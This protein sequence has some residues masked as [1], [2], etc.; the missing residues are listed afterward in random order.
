MFERFGSFS[1]YVH[2]DK[3]GTGSS[4][5]SVRV[6]NVDD[7]VDDLKA[8]MD[9]AEIDRAHLF[10]QSEAGV[11]TLLF[12]A[13]YPHRVASLIMVDSC[14]R[15][16][17]GDLTAEERAEQIERRTQF[18]KVW[19][20]PDSLAVPLFAPSQVDNHEFRAWFQRYER[21]SASSDSLRDLLIQMIDMDATDV[22]A[23]IEV[24]MLVMHRK[25]D[26]SIPIEFGRQLAD[27][28]RD[29]TFIELEGNDHFAFLGDVEAW[30]NPLERWVTGSVQDRPIDLGPTT[31]HVT[32]I[33]RFAV[34]V[35]GQDVPSNEWGSRRARTLLK[36]L[37]VARGWPVTRDELFD[38][39]WP[40]EADRNKLG[41]RLSVQLSHVRRVLGGGLIADRDTI[42]LDRSR[43]STD[44]DA[45][46]STDEDSELLE[47]ISGDFLP[48]DRYDDWAAPMR[49]ELRSTLAAALRRRVDSLANEDEVGRQGEWI[50]LARRLV[51]VDEWT[52][53]SHQRLISA[54]NAA[55]DET[56]ARIAC[57]RLK[58][59]GLD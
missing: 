10:A 44:L 50:A 41:A 54:L 11:T 8:V 31:A 12:A 55:G 19:G 57:D 42:A 43:V 13:A 56:G 27:R 35:D 22:I 38:L 24:P 48:D 20:T 51:D 18:A 21:L 49:E 58:D 2:Y 59:L 29:A 3:R 23:D 16:F 1:R 4:D 28:A 15:L 17:P 40:D 5:R 36:R 34:T 26:Q 47:L 39:L 25:G 9:A 45:A 7:R 53:A 6:P 30:M 46:L 52:A 32:T 14:A 37:V 33:G